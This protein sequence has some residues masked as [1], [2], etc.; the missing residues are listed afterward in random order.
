MQKRAVG[1]CWPL[2][3]EYCRTTPLRGRGGSGAGSV[4]F[5][6]PGD[7]KARGT[8]NSWPS[9][10]VVSFA[11]HRA[12]VWFLPGEYTSM[13]PFESDLNTVGCTVVSSARAASFGCFQG[14]A[15]LAF[16]LSRETSVVV[17]KSAFFLRP[18]PKGWLSGERERGCDK[19]Q[20]ASGKMRGGKAHSSKPRGVRPHHFSR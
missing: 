1:L 2:P 5:T 3:G 14:L 9:N 4:C 18:A 8:V 7:F 13:A 16:S 6:G 15:A 10:V 17:S 12:W 11:S 19:N 20:N